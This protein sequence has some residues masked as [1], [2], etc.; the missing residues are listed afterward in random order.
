VQIPLLADSRVVVAE[1]GANDV[2][3][4][5]P[6]PRE[7]ISDVPAAVRDALA[8]PLAGRPLSELVTKAGTATIVIEQPALPIPAVQ[9]G[10]RH[11]ATAAVSDELDRLGVE[12]I[13][14]L[15]AGG[16]MRRT[17][18][19]DIG[20]LVPPE[21]RR[22]FRGRVIVHDAEAD[23][24]VEL[25]QE[26]SVPLRVNP[27]LVETDL[28]VTVTAAE[29]VLHGGPA[30]LLG[31]SGHEALR[32][33]GALSLLETSGSQ[34][35]RLALELERLLAE[36]VPV[37]GVSL[38]LNLPRV[39]GPFAGYPHDDEAMERILRSHARRLFQV[40]PGRVRQRVLE[41]LPRELTAAAAF[42]GPPSVAH[43]EA[44]L[45]GTVFKGA[46]LDRQ[47]DALVIGIP[48]TTPF[49]P[50]EIPNP[51]SAAYLGL[52]LALRLWRNAPPIV[53][54]GTAI[55]CHPLPR[56]FPRPTQTPYRA[57]FFDPRT[58]RDSDAMRDA[59]R[60]ALD[61]DAAIADYRAGRACHPLQPFV[62]WSA[63]DATAHRLGAVLIAGCR[64]AQSARQLGYVPVHGLGAA[65]EM[66]RGRGAERIG[67]L[68]SPPYF[69][70]VVG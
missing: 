7:S 63:C 65:L 62:E 69:P 31:A 38:V 23:D 24:L 46:E 4:R 8:Y 56:R 13:T 47:V 49:V 45:R 27:A 12:R 42:G 60:A 16:L 48:P 11:V 68:L 22:R 18:P 64:D 30:A 6:P 70:L 36:R 15:V 10:P 17:T 67:F 40:A 32:A 25:G 5:P 59:E 21:F 34:G 53:Q 43:T 3:L 28:V 20:L 14:I 50:R 9:V 37:T 52:G 39:A 57:L 54:G 55:L 58:A 2:V 66:A 35:W 41:R 33:A 29:T 61:D 1:P 51:V 26:G 19:R 44:L